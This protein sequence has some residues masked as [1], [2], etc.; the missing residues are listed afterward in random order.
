MEEKW[1]LLRFQFSWLRNNPGGREA[2]YFEWARRGPMETLHL[3]VEAI[4]AK[5]EFRT[6]ARDAPG[7][8]GSHLPSLRTAPMQP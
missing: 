1:C 2:S 7:E 5:R 4:V 8:L 3:R 6:G